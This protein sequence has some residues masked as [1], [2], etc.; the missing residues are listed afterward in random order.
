MLR[1]VE[2]LSIERDPERFRRLLLRVDEIIPGD[3]VA[4]AELTAD[5]RSLLLVASD[6]RLEPAQAGARLLALRAQHPVLA[7]W[8]ET[9]DMTPMAISELADREAFA[10]TQLA[11]ELLELEIADQLVIPIPRCGSTMAV[12]INR[13]SWGF[14]VGERRLAARLQT[15]LSLSIGHRRH[16]DLARSAQRR[17]CALAAEHG[18]EVL[19]CDRCGQVM[20]ADG[21]AADV[22][23]L[24]QGAVAQA[25]SAAFAAAGTDQPDCIF[26]EMTV[27]DHGGDPTRVRVFA[28]APG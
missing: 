26:T 4:V 12:A 27:A 1:L 21:S 10:T 20:R 19:L 16:E 15:V 17:L 25:A 24:I 23:P 3:S 28:P 6:P 7:R 22:D 14:T 13:S 5:E 18:A 9:Q 11:R 8:E 2:G